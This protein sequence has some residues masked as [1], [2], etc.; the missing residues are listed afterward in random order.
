MPKFIV[1]M[2]SVLTSIDSMIM[3]N[4]YSEYFDM[5]KIGKIFNLKNINKQKRQIF[6]NQT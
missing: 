6:L 5:D 1:R 2:T 3:I 4:G